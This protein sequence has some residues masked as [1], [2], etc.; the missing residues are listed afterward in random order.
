V[1]STWARASAF[2]ECLR[3]R[4]TSADRVGSGNTLADGVS[5]GGAV[6]DA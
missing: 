1:F 6:S 4:I 3:L 2:V 5:A